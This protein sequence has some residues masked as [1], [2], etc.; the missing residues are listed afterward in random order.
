VYWSPR[1]GAHEVHGLIRG[2]WAALGW[3]AS[4]LGYPTSDEFAVA[5]GR[6]VNFERGHI[7][8]TSATG[9]VIDRRF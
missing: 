2:R 6:R 1:T 9:Q 4:Y 3:E 7:T 8:F 5:G